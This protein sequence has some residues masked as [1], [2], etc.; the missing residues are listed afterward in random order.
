[1]CGN[2]DSPNHNLSAV[3]TSNQL[4]AFLMCFVSTSLYIV[5]VNHNCIMQFLKNVKMGKHLLEKF[6]VLISVAIVW[7]YAHL[8]TVMGAYKH[9]SDATA[10]NCRTDRASLVVSSPWYANLEHLDCFFRSSLSKRSSLNG[11]Q[12]GSVE[13]PLK[14]NEY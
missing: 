2:R 4:H 3:V 7:G 13:N 5:I 9:A 12:L 10:S 8:L 6:S 14:L 11:T 1:M